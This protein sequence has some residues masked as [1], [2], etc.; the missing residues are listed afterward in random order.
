MSELACERG[1]GVALD[2]VH[3]LAEVEQQPQRR[4]ARRAELVEVVVARVDALLLQVGAPRIGIGAQ[5][6]ALVW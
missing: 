1:E 4:F 5:P 3:R 2:V 6:G